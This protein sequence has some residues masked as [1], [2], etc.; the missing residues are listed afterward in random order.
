MTPGE[1]RLRVAY[2]PGLRGLDPAR[3][4]LSA[5]HTI[6]VMGEPSGHGQGDWLS[7]GEC[8]NTLDAPR[9]DK[10]SKDPPGVGF[11]QE[12]SGARHVNLTGHRPEWAFEVQIPQSDRYQ[13]ALQT[14]GTLSASAYPSL[15]VLHTEDGRRLTAA[16]LASA[17]WHRLAVGSPFQ[18]AAGRHVLAVRLANDINYRGQTNRDAFIDRF[19]L[20]R[21]PSPNDKGMEEIA[22]MM[23]GQMAMT[24]GKDGP[25]PD[26]KKTGAPQDLA[27][28]FAR[29]FDGKTINGHVQIPG[30]VK[31]SNFRKDR[32]YEN[33][34]TG[35]VLNGR[36][37]KT[38]RGH[39]PSFR[40]HP[41]DLKPGKNFLRLV[42]IDPEGKKQVTSLE[43]TLVLAAKAPPNEKLPIAFAENR[44]DMHHKAWGRQKPQ[45]IADDGPYAE[46]KAPPSMVFLKSG[47]TAPRLKIPDHFHGR[48]R[49]SLQLRQLPDT[50][51]N[52]ENLQLL[53]INK[54][55][56]N[57]KEDRKFSVRVTEATEKAWCWLST[58]IFELPP[59]RKNR[60][61][62]IH[63]GTPG[64]GLALG[65]ISLQS[66]YF[67]DQSPPEL[68][69]DY[70]AP[71]GLVHPEGDAVVVRGFDDTRIARYELWVDG[72]KQG[73]NHSPVDTGPA[74]LA[75][76][77]STLAP[78]NH[79]L[80]V[81]AVDASGKHSEST[82]L[83]FAIP[84]E[85]D[86]RQLTLP[87]PRAVRLAERL[88]Y[89]ADQRSLAHILSHGEEAWIEEQIS[90]GPE[91][92]GEA[93]IRALGRTHFTK[94]NANEVRGRVISS[95]LLTRHPL[96]A[97]FV[98][99]AENHFSVW[100]NKTG[101][102]PK[103]I[104]HEGFRGAGLARF[105]DLLLLSAT[106]PAMM[107]YLDQQ[108]SLGKQLNENYAREILELHTVG[109]DAGYL[110]EDVTALAHLLTGWGAQKEAAMD[111]SD[112]LY[113][114]RFAPFLNERAAQEVYGLSLGESD[115]SLYCDDRILQFLEMLASR[116]E[117]ARFISR[118]LVSH[119]FAAPL[120]EPLFD[121]VKQRFLE[122]QGDFR[123]LLRIIA[124][125]QQLM[126]R[127]LEPKL[128]QPVEFGIVNQ[129]VVNSYHPWRVMSL[130][131][132]AGRNLYDRASPDGYPE[133]N[134]EYTGS[135]FQ[136]QKWLFA[137]DLE[138]K[139]GEAIPW[140]W[141][142]QKAL[143]S[144]DYQAALARALAMQLTRHPLEP[145][146]ALALT[147]MILQA[148]PL[149]DQ[150][151]RRFLLASFALMLPES[152]TR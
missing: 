57:K 105:N 27:V 120:P 115:L 18:L 76:D 95:A 93:L 61:L 6:H 80:R 49:I 66:P 121:R 147:K 33:I 132:R 14:K 150:N 10:I 92:P 103:W 62:Q 29:I 26:T 68:T 109:V 69:I 52:P 78:G 94:L 37:F 40:V 83:T 24:G 139:F 21:A 87:Y 110:Q 5:A 97:R 8:E 23:A 44:F 145:A 85:L 43:Q 74:V 82:E 122:T 70:P 54:G 146:A 86:P 72:Q 131:D 35:L 104:E 125:S 107:V 48:Y 17:T 30:L 102:R 51:Q 148:E 142:D 141:F 126:A 114:Y 134:E 149:A 135:N 36:P 42:A 138:Q 108:N 124:S 117:T 116:E 25:P 12:A 128:L 19:E 81:I 38:R 100:M 64:E 79:R 1:Q 50:N 34:L 118:K 20:R 129:R 53:L 73:F 137:K 112:Y 113:R 130:G 84:A 71:G 32:D 31:A 143:A 63:G 47:E 46:E 59:G 88:G 90:A 3:Q 7:T 89:G 136:L 99:W 151:Q 60:F 39:Y 11:D 28:A 98:L 65:G 41:H 67:V 77:T 106:S 2:L 140:H 144:P 15:E 111:G 123:D 16:R 133:E 55:H 58:E 119:Y 4:L 13:L 152:Q 127:D 45:P 9:S 75:W 96:R 56:G 91:A 101:S 22:M